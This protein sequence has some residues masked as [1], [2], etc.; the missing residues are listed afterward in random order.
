MAEKYLRSKG[1]SIINR[2][3]PTPFGEIDLV[4]V[5]SDVLVF[6]EVKT[7]RTNA[8]GHPLSSIDAFKKKHVLR[9]CQFYLSRYRL[10]DHPCRIDAVGIELN[11]EM[12][13]KQLTHV[14]NAIEINEH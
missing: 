11:N 14:K 13:L 4:A 10:W 6:V 5:D 12:E 1:L 3:F 8:Y 9:N 7:R 2:N